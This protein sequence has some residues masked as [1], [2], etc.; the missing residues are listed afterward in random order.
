MFKIC[1]ACGRSWVD[2]DEFLSSGELELLGYQ[3]DFKNPRNGLVLINHTCGNTLA[4]RVSLLED[5]YTGPRHPEP[6]L[7]TEFC[8]RYCLDKR[9]V[10]RCAAPCAYAFVREILQVLKLK[11]QTARLAAT[12]KPEH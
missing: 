6:Q 10:E 2:R 7:D 3:A 9:N 12:P 1:N 5:L 8:S 4:L 11:F